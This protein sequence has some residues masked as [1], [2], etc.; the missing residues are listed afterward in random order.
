MKI[1]RV[2]LSGIVFFAGAVFAA[3]AQTA[4]NAP[5]AAVKKPGEPAAAEEKKSEEETPGSPRGYRFRNIGPAAGGGRITA[6][7]SVP[8]NANVI[9][10]GSCSGGVFKTV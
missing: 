1:A 4:S 7:A 5:A 9:Y 10:V 6:I 8:G 2:V 3:P